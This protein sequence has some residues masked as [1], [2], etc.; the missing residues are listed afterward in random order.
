MK[1]LLS[2]AQSDVNVIVEYLV[3]FQRLVLGCGAACSAVNKAFEE[4]EDRNDGNDIAVYVLTFLW[5]FNVVY[6][7][8]HKDAIMSIYSFGIG[9]KPLTLL[10]TLGWVQ[11]KVEE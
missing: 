8:K 3:I 4:T 10:I 9:I 5:I 1:Q 2:I 7:I 6:I 11:P